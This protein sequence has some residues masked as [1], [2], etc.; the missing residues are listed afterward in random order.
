[1]FLLSS[2]SAT[3][4]VEETGFSGDIPLLPENLVNFN[5]ANAFYTGGFTDDSFALLSQLNYLNVDGNIFN[6]TIPAILSEL[7]NLEY[8]YMSDNFLVGDL[9]PLEGMPA[10]KEFWA[11]A[12]G[13]LAGPLY[14]WFGSMTT[15]VSLSLTYNN[16]TGSIPAEMGNLVEMEQMWLLFNNLTGTIPAELG[17]MTKLRHLELEA[18]AFTGFVQASI[19][20]QT[21][22]PL[23]TLKTFGADCYDE[24]FFCPCCTCCSITDCV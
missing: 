2:V 9:S 16:L 18:N 11:D 14:S 4:L 1:M 23:S 17:A 10:I 13:G 7:P 12:N 20:K 8:L 22:F 6:T 19:C 5:I 21:E 24:G 15:L 3:I